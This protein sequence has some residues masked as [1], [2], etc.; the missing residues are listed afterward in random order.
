MKALVGLLLCMFFVSA[1]AFAL[2]SDND[3]LTDDVESSL[4]SS[5]FHKDVFVEIDWLIVRG[6]NLKPRAGFTQIAT[7]IFENAPVSNPDGTTGIRL[8]IVF[9]NG[10]ST[11][12]DVVGIEN[13]NGSY[14]WA[15]FD[16]IKAQFFTPAN[17]A[18]HHYCL[19]V[20]DYAAYDGQGRLVESSGI[21]RNGTNFAAGASDLIVSLGGNGW[22]NKPKGSEYKWTQA[23]TFVHELGHNLALRH[24]GARS[25]FL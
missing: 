6:R 23:G 8:H 10:I 13:A 17:R 2:D 24:G 1:F 18:T 5:P 3:G 12:R 7:A 4:K 21:S 9:S 19:F 20:K 14:N 15:E 25:H 22:W 11:T 16:A